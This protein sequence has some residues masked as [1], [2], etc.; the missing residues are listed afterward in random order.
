MTIEEVL[1]DVATLLENGTN[2]VTTVTDFHAGGNP[3]L[4]EGL[5]RLKE[6][7]RKGG[8]SIYA[9]GSDPGFALE[10]L[11]F[12]F[13]AAQRKVNR[14]EIL[15]YGDMSRRP[16]PHMLFEQVGFG[17]PMSTFVPDARSEHLIDGYTQALSAL[18]KAAGFEID[19][20]SA[21]GEAAAARH[22]TK[23]IAGEIKAGTIAA[24]RYFMNIISGGRKVVTLE[25]YMYVTRDV[26]PDWGIGATGWRLKIDGD[27]PFD[28]RVD[29]PVPQDRI[30]E[31]VPAYNAN[32][33]VNAIPYLCAAPAG[34]VQTTDLTPILPVGP[35][36]QE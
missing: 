30:G 9:T 15:E 3:K 18:A 34:F 6:A 19:G 16:S 23:L 31:Y 29:F 4:G 20:V 26:E 24:H 5:E 2:V 7:C 11:P 8:A 27:A 12:A 10:Q 33:A 28:V 25:Q 1:D 32:L 14:I 17:K 36:M 35:T 21:H 22:D 13:L